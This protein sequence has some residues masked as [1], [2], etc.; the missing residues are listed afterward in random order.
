MLYG[1]NWKR[2]K[3]K[4]KKRSKTNLK[5]STAP[6][7]CEKDPYNMWAT[8][9]KE[10]EKYYGKN[11]EHV[12]CSHHFGDL[13]GNPVPQSEAVEKC[14][15]KCIPVEGSP[16]RKKSFRKKH[17]KDDDGKEVTLTEEKVIHD[18][19][20]ETLHCVANVDCG[21]D[22]DKTKNDTKD[23]DKEYADL[24]QKSKEPEADPRKRIRVKV[25][26]PCC[27]KF[28]NYTE[29]TATD[30]SYVGMRYCMQME[31]VRSND[32]TGFDG[33]RIECGSAGHKA[34]V[35][36]LTRRSSFPKNAD[37]TPFRWES[38]CEKAGTCSQDP[39]TGRP[40]WDEDVGKKTI[41]RRR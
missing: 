4:R 17:L 22:K 9:R 15:G 3:D 2:N 37:G 13:G 34:Y 6:S 29:D 32:G 31:G 40:E 25:K 11:S 7:W 24:N 19:T 8:S 39:D 21:K 14:T 36:E 20:T 10:L 23:F 5:G 38:N 26:A 30:P 41:A 28:G 27:K 16:W 33:S 12:N 18:F 1:T 35:E